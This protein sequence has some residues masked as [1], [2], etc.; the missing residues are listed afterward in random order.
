M[1]AS[2][3]LPLV[4]LLLLWAVCSVVQ[5]Q[6]E[7][8]TV[9]LCGREFIRAIVYTCGGSRWRRLLTPQNDVFSLADQSSVEELSESTGSN[10]STR[11]LNPMMTS[12]CCQVGCRKSDLSLLC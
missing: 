9:K 5:V 8:K 4:P 3:R 11:D 12:M 6:A 7:V 10:L 2:Y 1:R